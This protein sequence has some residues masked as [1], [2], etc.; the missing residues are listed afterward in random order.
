MGTTILSAAQRCPPPPP[1]PPRVFTGVT[2][3]I[4]TRARLP[5]MLP[6][7]RGIVSN[8]RADHTLRPTNQLTVAAASSLALLGFLRCGEALAFKRNE[9]SVKNRTSRSLKLT[10]QKSMTDSF[11]QECIRFVGSTNAAEAAVC[12]VRLTETYMSAASTRPPASPLFT[13][14]HGWKGC[15]RGTTSHPK[16]QSV[17]RKGL[18]GPQLQKRNSCRRTRMADPGH[19]AMDIAGLRGVHQDARVCSHNRLPGRPSPLPAVDWTRTE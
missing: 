8:V 4:G 16:P 3:S 11:R 2:R 17:Q 1:P 7:L 12:P 6:F 18:H 5:I 15:R 19:R 14:Q 10:I 9:I 13:R